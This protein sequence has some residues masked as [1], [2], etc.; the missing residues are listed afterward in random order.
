MQ[1]LSVLNP[2]ANLSE[3]SKILSKL[4][5]AIKSFSAASS[6]YQSPPEVVATCFKSAYL[7]TNA[8]RQSL[9]PADCAEY[10]RPARA[11]VYRYERRRRRR[12]Q[13][14]TCNKNYNKTAT[15]KKSNLAK[16]KKKRMK[17][18]KRAATGRGDTSGQLRVEPV[19]SPVC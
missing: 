4:L 2:K 7:T 5:K 18:S 14:V 11:L 16:M 13:S 3:L 8:T 15:I 1:I 17:K 10:I 12:A 6:P 19:E 9:Y